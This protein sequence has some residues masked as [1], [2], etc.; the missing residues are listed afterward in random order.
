LPLGSLAFSDQRA[1][2]TIPRRG[3]LVSHVFEDTSALLELL[4][5]A[6]DEDFE[7]EGLSPL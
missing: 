3:P 5:P 1:D 4:V 7:R 2:A 6:C